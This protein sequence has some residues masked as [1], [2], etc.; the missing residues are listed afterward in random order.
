MIFRGLGLLALL[1]FYG[2]YFGKMAMQK[3]QGI[4]IDHIAKGGKRGRLFRVEMTMK[5]A[6]CAAPVAELISVF[7]GISL[8]PV[9]ARYTGVL[10]AFAGVMCFAV[11]V[12]TMRDS[13]RAGIPEHDKTE[14]VTTGIYSISRNPAFLGFDMVYLGFLLMFFNPVLL[15]FTIFAVVMLHLQILQEEKFMADTFG[16]EYEK[17]RKH[18]FRYIGSK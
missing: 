3:K 4:Q 10:A 11:S 9:F 1:L 2:V 16:S 12:Y 8:L 5:A 15:V 6:T 17:Y 7:T 13:W 14:M 18:V